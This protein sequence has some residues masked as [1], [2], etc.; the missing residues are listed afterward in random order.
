MPDPANKLA[1]K[2]L[3]LIE[4]AL[5]LSKQGCTLG[6]GIT[7]QS[8]TIGFWLGRRL[9]DLIG[10][11]RSTQGDAARSTEK[12]LVVAVGAAL[13]VAL[14]L[15][16]LSMCELGKIAGYVA[17]YLGCLGWA[18]VGAALFVV[19]IWVTSLVPPEAFNFADIF[20]DEVLWLAATATIQSLR[21]SR[22]LTRTCLT[23]ARYA[24]RVLRYSSAS[25]AVPT[26][27]SVVAPWL[28][29]SD[30]RRG[31]AGDAISQITV[32]FSRF[33]AET[34]A[35]A[36]FQDLS[37]AMQTVL[38]KRNELPKIPE[39]T[40]YEAL[41]DHPDGDNIRRYYRFTLGTYG[42]AAL[43][44]LQVIPFGSASTDDNAAARCCGIPSTDVVHA[45]YK[46]GVYQPG[47]V[48]YIDRA[49]GVVVVAMRGSITMQDAVTDFV[50]EAADCPDMCDDGYAHA[51]ILHSA[52]RMGPRILPI[53][54][55]LLAGQ[56]T[57]YG[58][59]ICGHSL[60]AGVAALVC[61]MWKR[62]ES[63][64][65]ERVRDGLRCYSYGAPQAVSP[66]LSKELS[67]YVTS[68]TLA[69]DVIARFSL[70]SMERAQRAVL[71]L[72]AGGGD[73]EDWD[74]LARAGG[75]EKQLLPPGRVVWLAH[76]PAADDP[77]PKIVEVSD[78]LEFFK[79]LPASGAM[80]NVHVPHTLHE[81]L[82]EA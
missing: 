68:V 22:W 45:V 71:K 76:K 29:R 6:F 15:F 73:G 55:S 62:K 36:R 80:F 4:E 78:P 28:H 52:R 13:G 57:G 27:L 74:S 19:L 17:D 40:V 60:G 18:A 32:T 41:A 77:Q 10:K 51:G 58:L 23:L 16:L 14:W 82:Q 8:C 21:A 37:A 50:C 47:Y 43:K 38:Q 81:T 61:K 53:V 67:D 56:C 33:I 75:S 63:G 12:L 39:G 70:Y 5:W 64:L 66:A 34:A 30:G 31:E 35:P 79:D 49:R 20:V 42:H 59:V 3:V 24:V 69:N 48:V 72:W 7:I 54:R 9:L 65:S 46:G 11:L 25:D 2:S 44:F 1:Q 26:L